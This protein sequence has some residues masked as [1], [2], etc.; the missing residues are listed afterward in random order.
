MGGSGTGTKIST[1][2]LSDIL[3]KVIAIVK[4]DSGKITNDDYD[5]NISAALKRYSKHKPDT[6]VKDITSPGGHDIDLPD[7]WS[8]D[9]SIITALEHPVENVPAS[10]LDTESYG[11]Y[12]SPSGK[13]IRL[14]DDI[15]SS[16]E[17]VRVS[18]TI[19][20]T[21]ETMPEIDINALSNLAAS[22]CL[23]DLANAYLQTSDPTITADVVNYRSK[24]SEAAARA[25]KLMQLYKDHMGL[26]ENDTTPP[27]S[28]VVDLDEKY[29]GGL[30]R[31]THPRW[32]R[33]KR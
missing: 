22:L 29:P 6:A 17:K 31:L 14:I 18:F 4:D 11:T 3:S 9:F 10:I 19:I 13:K 33:V 30:E 26:K 24:S 27:A 21:A 23:E 15:L 28:A 12:Q 16:G 1:E 25:K 8:V 2:H 32:A 5:R 7:G 20:R